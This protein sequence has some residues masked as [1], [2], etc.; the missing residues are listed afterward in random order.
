[1]VLVTTQ[2]RAGASIPSLCRSCYYQ[3]RQLRVVSRSLSPAAAS[4]LVHA[5]VV[6]LFDYCSAIYEGLPICRLK[7]LDR[8]LRTAARLLGR[9]PR[10]G[11][12]SGYMRDVLHWLP[13]P[14]TAH[15]LSHLCVGSAL[16][17]GTSPILFPG[18]L[19][20]HCYY[21]V[22]Y[23]IALFCPSGVAGP[24]PRTVIRQRR[25]FSVACPTAWNGL[26]VELR[27]TPVAQLA[28]FLSSLK[29]TLFDRCWAGSAPE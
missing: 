18:N 4:N 19:L 6:S 29:T 13:Y 26:P 2:C 8:V 15:C 9:I 11:R 12:V 7:C 25:A 3:L 23:L 28:L 16:H 27:L 24:R 17:R 14:C 22:S 1:M 5:F 10:F 21:S 20:L